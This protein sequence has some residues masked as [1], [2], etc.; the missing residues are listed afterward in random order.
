MYKEPKLSID[1]IRA[2]S[3]FDK[4]AQ[5][6]LVIVA[7]LGHAATCDEIADSFRKEYS[8]NTSTEAIARR[9]RKMVKEGWLETPTR[10]LYV[11]VK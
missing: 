5:E 3:T 9:T 10:G 4:L 8:K 7:K 6:I 11:A 2:L 1:L